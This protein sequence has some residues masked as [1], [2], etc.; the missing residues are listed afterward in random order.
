MQNT[1]SLETGL[2]VSDRAMVRYLN[3]RFEL[4]YKNIADAINALGDG[5]MDKAVITLVT[6]VS[7]CAATCNKVDAYLAGVKGTLPAKY[8]E[9]TAGPSSPL[10]LTYQPANPETDTSVN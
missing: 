9:E 10:Q 4:L 6:L 1:P 8:F 3:A 2:P 7:G 5:D